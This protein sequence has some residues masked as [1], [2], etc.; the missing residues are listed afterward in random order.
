MSSTTVLL[1]PRGRLSSRHKRLGI[2]LLAVIGFLAIPAW[3]IG[4]KDAAAIIDDFATLGWAIGWVIGLHVVAIACDG[5]GWRV[6][7]GEQSRAPIRTFIGAR[8]VRE[9]ANRLLPVAQIGGDVVGA[10]MLALRGLP[11]RL[12][13]ASVVLDKLAEALSQLPF[14]VLGLALLIALRGET[15]IGEA[16]ALAL[17]AVAATVAA[18][19]LARRIGWFRAAERRLAFRLERSRKPWVKQIERFGH[20]LRAIYRPELLAAGAGWHLIGWLIGTGEVWLALAFMGHPISLASAVA[21][22]SLGQAITSIGFFV[23]ASLGVQEGAYIVIGSALG[24]PAETALALA[25]VKRVRQIALGLPALCSWQALELRHL[26]AAA[27]DPCAAPQDAPSSHSNSYV[28]CFMRGALRP[29]AATRLTPNAI[30]GLRVATGLAACAACGVG[31]PVWNHWAALLWLVS[32][33]LDRGD[34]EFARLA[35]RCTERGRVFDYWSDVAINALV[36]L[37]VGVNLRGATLGHWSVLIG[38]VAAAAVALAAILA[39][40]LEL[41]IGQKT[42]PSRRGFDFDDILFVLVPILWLGFLMPLLIGAALGGVAAAVYIWYRLSQFAPP[43]RYERP[44]A[45]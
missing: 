29:F 23:P 11:A 1:P 41:R 8:W 3:V 5:V 35:G 37:A 20:A 34:G 38:A 39:E 14:T 18:L 21:L 45:R 25:L 15:R 33:L 9:A 43:L 27:V 12:A 40:A 17:F 32:A 16:V 2:G 36:F 31:A 24:L 26:L 19:F 42:V 6:L 22:E 30:T 4:A 28:R 13:G 10:R 7:L 44:L